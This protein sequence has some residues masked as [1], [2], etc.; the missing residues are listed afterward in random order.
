MA[1]EPQAGATDAGE[2][3]PV[4]LGEPA[5]QAASPRPRAAMPDRQNR[6]GKRRQSRGKFDLR[7]CRFR[8]HDRG[9]HVYFPP[10][11]SF[12]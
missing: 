1:V 10:D 3:D 4:T 6:V 2:L 9:D 12:I 5:H 11:P 8:E 7:S